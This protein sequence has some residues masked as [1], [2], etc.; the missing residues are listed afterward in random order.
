V[1]AATPSTVAGA[2]GAALPTKIE[3]VRVEL[4]WEAEAC[5]PVLVTA[6]R[7]TVTFSDGWYG[8]DA[9]GMAPA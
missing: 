9:S 2:S 7:V 3:Q 6:L 1:Q 5:H 8:N 4:A